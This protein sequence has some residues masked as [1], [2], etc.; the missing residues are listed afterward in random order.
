M[1]AQGLPGT[2]VRPS[3]P[4]NGAGEVLGIIRTQGPCSRAALVDLLG[5][6]RSTVAQRLDLLLQ[7][8]LI[9]AEQG[10][11][12]TRGRPTTLFRFNH[13]RGVV[14]AA[15]LGV[16]HAG[17]AVT[18]LAGTVL[19][20][21][22]HDLEIAAG[23]RHVL[24]WLVQRF[25]ELLDRIGMDPSRVFGVGVGLPGPV[26]ASTGTPVRPPIMPG[27]DGF[28]VAQHL[29]DHYRVPV[30][31]DNDV[32]LLALGEQ[33]MHWPD[34]EHLLC[35]KVAT[36]IGMGII[37]DGRLARG[38]QGAAGDL[39]HVH[40][41]DKQDY[42]CACGNHGCLEAVAGGAALAR[43][44]TERGLPVPD[45]RHI[46]G[47]AK[48]GNTEVADL[49]RQAGRLIGEVLATVV[50][51]LNPSLIIITG[52]L[53]QAQEQLLT[54]IRE[55]IYSRSLPLATRDL[56]IV[57]SSTPG[58]T[59]IVGAAAIVLDRVLAPAAIDRLVSTG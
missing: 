41:A 3:P 50:N 49:L 12:G 53:A 55:M 18:D 17:V 13:A 52:D 8:D 4:A 15:D 7:R 21:T 34:S 46:I 10:G 16:T 43:R 28:P 37:T 36:G 58:S 9:V 14:L 11:G 26:E 29:A 44:L 19:A 56:R 40:L 33:R 22:S 51:V 47:L 27:W 35:V 6:A 31:V 25:T 39:G 42:L 48:Q 32:N 1:S 5:V 45:A 54:G 30:L 23:P 24:D 38:A 59:G 2:L 20:D 57:V